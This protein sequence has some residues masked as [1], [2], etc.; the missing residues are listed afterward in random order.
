M[1][2]NIL[3]NAKSARHFWLTVPL[4]QIVLVACLQLPA[5]LAVADDLLDRPVSMD[6]SNNTSLEDA[7]IEWGVRAGVTVM[8]STPTVENRLVHSVHGTLSA[9]KALDLLLR[10]TGLSY[11]LDGTRVHIVAL[12]SLVPSSFSGGGADQ[13]NS[14]PVSDSSGPVAS[15]DVERSSPTGGAGKGLPEVLVTAQKREERLQDVP[16]PV[17]VVSADSLSNTNQT[18][19]QDF[20]SSI[21][22]VSFNSGFF[23]NTVTI[24]GISTV[25]NDGVS[26]PTVGIVIDDVPYGASQALG[27]LSAP[28]L[29]P[30][31]LERIEVLRGPQGT[32]YGASSVGGLI[33]Y[34]TI[35][36]STDAL[37]GHVQGGTE[38]VYN[39]IQ[40]GYNIR[41]SLNVPIT[42]TVAFRLSGFS[43]T[44]PGYVD[45]IETGQN[46]VNSEDVFGGRASVLWRPDDAISL[47]VSALTQET[48]LYGSPEVQL[49]VDD[50]QQSYLRGTGLV[51]TKVQL[52]TVNFS[53]KLA[54]GTLTS[55]SAYTT[56]TDARNNDLSALNGLTAQFVPGSSGTALVNTFGTKKFSQEIRFDMPITSSVDWL[57]GLFY[58][59][60]A[61]A[62]SNYFN[63]VDAQTG[64][65]VGN[66]WD[67]YDPRTFKEYAGFT[68]LTW[69]ITDEFDVQAGGRYSENK[70]THMEVISGSLA[71]TLLGV[72]ISV[73]PLTLSQDH[74][75]TYLLTPEYKLSADTMVYSRISSGYQVG[76]ANNACPVLQTI[77]AP[78][79]YG[80]STVDNYEIGF[81]S[82]TPSQLLSIDASLYYID[83]RNIQIDITDAAVNASYFVNAGAAKSEGAEVS[84]SSSPLTGLRL[85]AWV[86]FDD[87]VLTKAFPAQASAVGLEGDRLPHSSR[88]SGN[89]SV[90]QEISLRNT[91]STFVG[92]SI[93]YI[94]NRA[95]DFRPSAS[96]PQPLFPGYAK[97]DIHLGLRGNSWQASLYGNNLTDRRGLLSFDP[98]NGN[99]YII[100]QP[101][102]VGVSL[103]QSF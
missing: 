39:G 99:G 59:R 45:N 85:S 80:P 66:E 12:D 75:L 18:R 88:F 4:I 1:K 79:T 43:R 31:D 83:W 11:T 2:K 27:F 63:G 71:P 33:K 57:A 48:K 40:P 17:S 54:G 92:G 19:I 9:R 47:K 44:D 95:Q 77:N 81:K 24:R 5:G 38:G 67:N 82:S 64:E 42:S 65:T 13:D 49:N 36:P 29:D 101:R 100:I 72:P 103:S 89:L 21:P 35:D 94:G 74:S 60:E 20:Y 84:A 10:N 56:G 76:G 96:E 32:L 52:Y 25:G 98:E 69:R 86:T 91:L 37:S 78:C 90:D 73:D 41:G 51:D 30:G 58:T 8:M 93:S 14:P 15:E 70:Q 6:I 53:A 46:A 55:V 50:L 62:H 87:A 23:S 61:N 22:G 26:I 16:V 68:D 28:D 97:L 34:V 102:T 3:R 7:L